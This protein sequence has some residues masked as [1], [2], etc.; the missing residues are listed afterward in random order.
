[1]TDRPVQLVPV[2]F[3][4]LPGW[5]VD[6]TENAVLALRR[7]PDLLRQR[8]TSRTGLNRAIWSALDAAASSPDDARRFWEAHFIPHR[9]VHEGVSGL[10]TGYFDPV[11]RGSLTPS[12]SFP[13]PVYRRPPDLENLVS[14]AERASAASGFSH[15]R[16]TPAGLE[17]FATRR[18]IENGA[19]VRQ[20]LELVWLADP[21]DAF[22]L[23]VQGSGSVVLDD[24]RVLR[25]A[26]DGKNGHP[27]T[28]IGR[29]LI[30]RGI[31]A[32]EG[33]TLDVL[34][35]WLRADPARAREVM[36][37]NASFVF[38]RAMADDEPGP[39]GAEGTPLT[40]GRSLA[41]DS[42]VHDLGLP[43]HVV[44][45]GLRIDGQEFRRLM[46]AQD[47]GSAIRGPERGDIYVG[48]GAEAG[49]IAGAIKHPATFFVLRPRGAS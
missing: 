40:P 30:E 24:G 15:M 34:A 19:L 21:V 9:V 2:T 5:T 29:V 10:V 16:R 38:F 42:S 25:L 17:P 22:I 47:V 43:I 39:L 48:S 4:E 37:H 28:S 1:M 11:Y 46:I 33:L 7:V 32:A 27:Y 49:R 14:E 23:H 26:Y 20:G 45:T 41:V 6:A 31:L 44:A 12:A 36:W 18:E 35:D 8:L 13:V 3:A